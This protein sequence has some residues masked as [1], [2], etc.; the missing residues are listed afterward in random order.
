MNIHI[1]TCSIYIDDLRKREQRSEK[2]ANMSTIPAP[3]AGRL[4]PLFNRC[5]P[6]Q[7]SESYRN[8]AIKL[9]S[10]VRAI[11]KG[12]GIVPELHERD[13]DEKDDDSWVEA[14]SIARTN[15]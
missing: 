1:Y 7:P 11:H 14:E 4:V 15:P 5:S 13:E 3:F 10:F 2:H 6:T 8:K 9:S 12:F